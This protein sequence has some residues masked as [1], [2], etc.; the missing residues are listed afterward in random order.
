M[1]LWPSVAAALLGLLLLV[2]LSR[3]A[4]FYA[5]VALYCALCFALSAAASL[6]CLLRHGGRTVENMSAPGQ[7]AGGGRGPEP[8]GPEPASQNPPRPCAL[9]RASTPRPCRPEWGA[10]DGAAVRE[11]AGSGRSGRG[12]R[13]AETEAEVAG[14][15]P[16]AVDG[17]RSGMGRPSSSLRRPPARPPGDGRTCGA[18]S[19]FPSLPLRREVGDPEGTCFHAGERPLASSSGVQLPS[20]GNG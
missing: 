20:E 1:E 6:V 7:A 4:E 13:G 10:G 16:R 14:T 11:K 18:G 15:C 8:G 17:A 9:A 2:Q 3:A 5:K 19:L 12:F